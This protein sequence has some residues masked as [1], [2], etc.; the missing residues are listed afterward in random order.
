M[1]CKRSTWNFDDK[2]VKLINCRTDLVGFSAYEVWKFWRLLEY[3]IPKLRHFTKLA[4]L[5]QSNNQCIC[6]LKFWLKQDREN[7][8]FYL[9]FARLN[10]LQAA[11]RIRLKI[12][13]GSWATI[14]NSSREF[15]N[16]SNLHVRKLFWK[17][18]TE[19]KVSF[20]KIS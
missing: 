16:M 11:S 3:L 5:L 15:L 9:L 2:T 1:K 18:W 4:R 13:K 17:N 10:I 20:K 7:M 8:Q 19:L 12:E 14:K 6:M